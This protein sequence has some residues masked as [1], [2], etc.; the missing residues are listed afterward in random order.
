MEAREVLNEMEFKS[1]ESFKTYII[2]E[3]ENLAN[4]S[5]DIN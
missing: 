1:W 4:D 5:F 2:D 3:L